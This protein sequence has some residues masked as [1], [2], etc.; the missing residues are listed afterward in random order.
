M[1]G[2]QLLYETI[3]S[4]LLPSESNSYIVI[5]CLRIALDLLEI[6]GLSV[7]RN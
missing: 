5:H 3:Q 1:K 2:K 4:I 7:I 6:C